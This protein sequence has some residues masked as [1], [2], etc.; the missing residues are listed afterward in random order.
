MIIKQNKI[1]FGNS[2]AHA[3]MNQFLWNL[4]QAIFNSYP[5]IGKKFAQLYLI[6]QKVRPFDNKIL[7]L[8]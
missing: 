7:Q 8:V 4:A 3:F 1:H 5:N 2:V 6:L